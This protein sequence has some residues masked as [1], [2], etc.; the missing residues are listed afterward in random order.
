MA[1]AVTI[2]ECISALARQVQTPGKDWAVV[3]PLWNM[4]GSWRRYLGFLRRILTRYEAANAAYI[5][6]AQIWQERARQEAGSGSR[7]PTPDEMDDWAAKRD[8]AEAVHLEVESFYQFAK[9]L[10]DRVADTIVL[11]FGDKRAPYG[12]SH[13][14]LVT[15]QFARLCSTHAL[16]GQTVKPLMDDLHSRIVRHETDVIEHLKNPKLVPGTSFGA[17]GRAGISMGMLAPQP[18]EDT[19]PAT[20][21]PAVL[22]EA[23]ETYIEAVVDFLERHRDQ[24]AV[25]GQE[26]R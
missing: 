25:S 20:E 7:P 21:D 26:E 9:I 15:K 8:S 5:R 6:L 22:F 19:F 11:Y 17:D 2:D 12:S 14:Q 24:S 16:A 18:E 3:G 23:I 10:L 13:S 4:I 1:R